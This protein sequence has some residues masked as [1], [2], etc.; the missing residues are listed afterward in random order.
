MKRAILFML[1]FCFVV[2]GCSAVK[3]KRSFQQGVREFR[4]GDNVLA[5]KSAIE[6]L[7]HDPGHKSAAALLGWTHLRQNELT[8][9]EEIFTG[10]ARAYP[11]NHMVF[12]AMGWLRLKQGQFIEA[13][14]WFQKQKLWATDYKE[15][16][17]YEII[18]PDD[19][20]YIQSVLSDAW[21]GL[22]ETALATGRTDMAIMY[23]KKA[24]LYPNQFTGHS[25]VL[26]ILGRLHA[27]RGD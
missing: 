3:A 11:S 9:A 24:L 23:L 25:P 17:T 7:A 18:G 13:E 27:S 14:T 16:Y 26:K 20:R 19:Q 10:L 5:K 15:S 12:Q 1:I 4:S 22:G 2:S 8:H 6:T 21:Y